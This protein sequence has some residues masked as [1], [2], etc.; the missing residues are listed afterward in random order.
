MKEIKFISVYMENFKNHLQMEMDFSKNELILLSGGNGSGKS[1]II[2]SLLYALYDETANSN[3]AD[4]VV[5]KKIGKNCF[6]LLKFKVDN[7]LYEIHRYRKHK[8]SGNS[9]YL[10]KNGNDISGAE[11]K[12]TNKLIEQIV[13]K[14]DIFFNCM[15]FSQLTNKPFISMSHSEQ[16]EIL[17]NILSLS[18]YDEYLAKVDAEIKTIKE[19]S[20]GTINRNHELSGKYESLSSVLKS[21]EESLEKLNETTKIKKDELVEKIKE[22]NTSLKS[23]EFSKDDYDNLLKEKDELISL[24]RI[25]NEK[26]SNQ[27][28][29]YKVELSN[30]KISI[31]QQS[32]LELQ[33][34]SKESLLE[35]ESLNGQKLFI[36]NNTNKVKNVKI[37]SKIDLLKE[38]NEKL[39]ELKSE[40]NKQCMQYKILI[41]SIEGNIKEINNELNFFKENLNNTIEEYTD[42]KDKFEAEDSICHTCNQSL[43]T[44]TSI[45]KIKAQIV[46]YEK[47]IKSSEESISDKQITLTKE[48]QNLDVYKTLLKEYED[49]YKLELSELDEYNVNINLIN[50][51]IADIEEKLD[52]EISE[53]NKQLDIIN[54]SIIASEKA[55]KEKYESLLKSSQEE[56]VTKHKIIATEWTKEIEIC[57]NKK[58]ILDKKIEESTVT[59]NYIEKIVNDIRN[60]H[61]DLE[62][63]KNNFL[64]LSTSKEKNIFDLKDQINV[65]IDEKEKIKNDVDGVNEKLEIL[66]FWKTAF[67][68]TGI[69]NLILDEAIPILNTKAI[70]LSNMTNNIRVRFTSQQLIKSGDVRNKFDI[71]VLNT[72]N[73]SEI[74]EFSA[75]EKRLSNIIV[76]LCLR[77]LLEIMTNTRINLLLL[78]EILDSLDEDNSNISVDMIKNNFK[79]YCILLISHTLKPYIFPDK[80]YIL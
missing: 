6:V 51:D 20:Q 63:L 80:E 48:Q 64:E 30:L 40:Y 65:I 46:E 34:N 75:G 12:D 11:I 56:L 71:N 10:L 29:R 21:E 49:K 57:E 61:K 43:K 37:K 24:I 14:K 23:I 27:R 52:I 38:Y 47:E 66:N 62:N 16:K 13:M 8:K 76:L 72:K 2:D 59:R 18:V 39:D 3:K 58:L 7:D 54:K 78:D 19:N 69:K 32:N 77:N 55:I 79:E 33:T 74:N 68:D 42:I 73:L 50:K 9:K 60:Y 25:Y 31:E 35:K 22:F 53:I 17:D 45:E 67:G 15:L 28:E 5:N 4:S 44:Q 26:I 70:E 41:Q 1:S 36:T